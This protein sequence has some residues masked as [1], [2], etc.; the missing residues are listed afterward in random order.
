MSVE[1]ITLICG[2][3]L[4]LFSLVQTGMVYGFC[5]WLKRFKEAP[6]NHPLPHTAV[7]LSV[8]GESDSLRKCLDALQR[9]EYPSYEIH[10]IVDHEKD[11]SLRVIN[12]WKANHQTTL[13]RI[14]HLSDVSQFAS[15][16]TSAIRQCIPTL[17]D[18]VTAIA[19]LDADTI[20]HK[21]W[22]R[23]LVTPLLAEQSGASTGNRWYDCTEAKL[24][25]QIR[26]LYNAWAVP[27]MH[28]MNTVWGG[29]LGISQKVFTHPDF[30][31]TLAKTP[32]EE[33]GVQEI[34]KKL[35]LQLAKQGNLFMAQSGDITIP[36]ALGFITRQ[37][38]WTR[39]HYREWIGVLI[40][41]LLIYAV[42]VCLTGSAAVSWYYGNWRAFTGAT[43][44]FLVYWIINWLLI[45][46]LNR[47]VIDKLSIRDHRVFPRSTWRSHLAVFLM[48]PI[49][50]VF[51]VVAL[52]KAQFSSKIRWSGIEYKICPPHGIELIEYRPAKP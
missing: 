32:T 44:L 7:I 11:Q 2:S 38:V 49:G 47:T 31:D 18:N 51:F 6:T 29:S 27:G 35:G 23:E 39:L 21:E 16:K 1:T 28:F 5:R 52:L 46:Y 41:P 9:L 34:R 22:L 12:P 33:I 40:G 15:L 10:V 17:N 30:L 13:I 50:F 42:T 37:L 36:N 45:L 4:S 48:I 3:L 24:G 25:N 20:V 43:T 14:H 19:I 26:F 8:R